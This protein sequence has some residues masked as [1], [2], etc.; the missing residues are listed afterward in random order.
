MV[1]NLTDMNPH[2]YF[3][4]MLEGMLEGIVSALH[5]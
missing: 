4:K 2:F 3:I 5:V 1:N